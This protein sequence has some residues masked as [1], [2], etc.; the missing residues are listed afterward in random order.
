MYSCDFPKMIRGN[1][2]R[3]IKDHE[4]T[5]N[6]LIL[7]LYSEKLSLFGD[8]NFGTALNNALFE[9]PSTALYDIVTDEILSVI[10]T[11]MPSIYVRRKDITVYSE[12]TL[13]KCKIGCTYNE[14]GENDL[15]DIA[16]TSVGVIES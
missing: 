4:A 1:K 3:L 5:K 6:N 7:L 14:T 9:N 13:L 2:V 10:A 12:G 15:F 16:L 8:P 11:Y